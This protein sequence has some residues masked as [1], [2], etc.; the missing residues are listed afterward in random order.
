MLANNTSK[1][2]ISAIEISLVLNQGFWLLKENEDLF[3]AYADFPWFKE[4]T[5]AQITNVERPSVDHLYWPSLDIDLSV[6]SVRDP[7]NFPLISK[8]EGH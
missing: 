2:S 5:I 3:L 6:D 7:S 1:S 8:I 4:A